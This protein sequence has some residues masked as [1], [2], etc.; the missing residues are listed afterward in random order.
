MQAT[1]DLQTTRSGPETIDPDQHMTPLEGESLP[2]F[3]DSDHRLYGFCPVL[4]VFG[5]QESSHSHNA[6]LQRENVDKCVE[7]EDTSL[8]AEQEGHE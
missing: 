8:N 7:V 1:Q 4:G 3:L 5:R 2:G 6:I